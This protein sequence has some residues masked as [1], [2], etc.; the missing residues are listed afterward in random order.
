MLPL[1]ASA[2]PA[3][4]EFSVFDAGVNPFNEKVP[5]IPKNLI[6]APLFTSKMSQLHLAKDFFAGCQNFLT[7]L[8][9][10]GLKASTC[11]SLG[12][13]SCEPERDHSQH[14]V[15]ERCVYLC[16]ALVHSIKP[17][18]LMNLSAEALKKLKCVDTLNTYYSDHSIM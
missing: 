16:T 14:R 9:A 17:K 15:V 3:Y 8:V 1:L 12:S 18:F 7:H 11:G 13:L 6:D 10:I 5:R 2:V 4:A